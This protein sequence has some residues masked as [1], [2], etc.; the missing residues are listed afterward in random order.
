ML[1]HDWIEYGGHRI[2][3]LPPE[4]RSHVSAF[5]GSLW[6]VGQ[7]SGLVSFLEIEYL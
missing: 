7:M 1:D 5:Y 6:A 3:W 2:L 4:Y